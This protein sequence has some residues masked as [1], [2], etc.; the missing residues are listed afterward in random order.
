MNTE[1]QQANDE[2]ESLLERMML[3]AN[4]P[5][6][7]LKSVLKSVLESAP[8]DFRTDL[9]ALNQVMIAALKTVKSL[10]AKSIEELAESSLN[11]VV[12]HF[13]EHKHEPHT[14]VLPVSSDSEEKS[15]TWACQIALKLRAIL[16]A[17]VWVLVGSFHGETCLYTV[18]G[19]KLS[20]V[21]GAE[22]S[23]GSIVALILGDEV[24]LEA[25]AAGE[26][27]EDCINRV[28]PDN[29]KPL[30]LWSRA[31]PHNGGE[32]D[33]NHYI[34]RGHDEPEYTD[35]EGFRYVKTY[36]CDKLLT[37]TYS[38]QR[39]KRFS[40]ADAHHVQLLLKEAQTDSEIIPAPAVADCPTPEPGKPVEKLRVRSFT[41]DDWTIEAGKSGKF[42]ISR[43]HDGVFLQEVFA[44]P[45]TVVYGWSETVAGAK[46][47][48]SLAAANDYASEILLLQ[49]YRGSAPPQMSI[50]VGP[51]V[52]RNDPCPC[53]SGNKWKKC[54][55]GVK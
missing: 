2:L 30:S 11:M 26:S 50:K 43:T 38:A 3:P 19:K 28:L 23:E 10:P 24:Q 29:D 32:S 51:K 31:E 5:K 49:T 35:S 13:Q 25:V 4:F 54:C 27:W 45:D 6:C 36:N 21:I 53:G 37:W 1:V 15:N 8:A 48:E 33:T 39:A 20:E 52:G 42:Y 47:F 18:Q 12:N 40:C 41:D 16:P 9:S 34:I 14:F 7:I 22:A 17:T 44:F 55:M 46:E